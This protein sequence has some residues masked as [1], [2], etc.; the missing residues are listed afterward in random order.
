[1]H[2]SCVCCGEHIAKFDSDTERTAE[3]PSYN[4]YELENYI[5]DDELFLCGQCFRTIGYQPVES[6]RI[7]LYWQALRIN[8]HNCMCSETHEKLDFVDQ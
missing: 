4:L 2:V 5:L 7:T 6:N 8:A 1:M 3:G